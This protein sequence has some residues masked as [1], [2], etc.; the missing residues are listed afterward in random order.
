ML[1]LMLFSK[2]L[3]VILSTKLVNVAISKVN[4]MAG[5]FTQKKKHDEEQMHLLNRC[6][7]R[8]IK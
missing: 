3:K 7:M 2:E 4:G 1:L 6:W 8:N 5:C